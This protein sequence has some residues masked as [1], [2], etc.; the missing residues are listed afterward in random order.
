VS[1]WPLPQVQGEREDAPLEA[2][3][4]PGAGP[5]WITAGAKIESEGMTRCIVTVATG[6]YVKGQLRLLTSL[7]CGTELKFYSGVL[8]PGSP[9]H[10]QKPYAFKAY[11]LMEAAKKYD[12]LLWC[13]ASIIPGA[14]PLDDLWKRIEQEGYWF[15]R[16]YKGMDPGGKFP[17]ER[18]F[19]NGEW[20]A[21]DA[22][23]DLGITEDENNDIDQVVATAFGL[24]LKHWRGKTFLDHYYAKAQTNAF[25][26]PWTGGPGI[27]HRHDQTAAS[28]IAYRLGFELTDPPEWFAYAGTDEDERTCLVV[29]GR[30]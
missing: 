25:C 16:N 14:R 2:H 28:V 29:D 9:T 20:T 3:A 15:S 13:D 30:F 19:K 21:H 11:A 24:N 18:P 6:R 7:P 5:L 8:P 23:P 22:L 26:G 12:L 1:L 10:E 4:L 27:Q 17:Y